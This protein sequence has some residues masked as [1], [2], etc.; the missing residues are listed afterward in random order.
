M[1]AAWTV[2]NALQRA[3]KTPT[4][5]SFMKALTTMNTTA[6][7]FLLKG[8]RLQTSVTDRFFVEDLTMS[9]WGSGHWNQFGPFY[10]HAR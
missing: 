9:R 3:G 8:V 5:A 10:H 6:D 2:V 1:S 4:R 7:P